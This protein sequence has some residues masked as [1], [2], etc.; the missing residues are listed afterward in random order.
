MSEESADDLEIVFAG[1][2]IVR[3]VFVVSYGA[4]ECDCACD[5]APF[6]Q[7]YCWD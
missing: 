5:L 1:A 7:H 4:G 6:Y 3:R 2:Y